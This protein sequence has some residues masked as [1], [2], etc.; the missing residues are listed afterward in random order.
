[1]CLDQWSSTGLGNRNI[2]ATGLSTRRASLRATLVVEET[3]FAA[4]H[5]HLQLMIIHYEEYNTSGLVTFRRPN[6][7]VYKSNELSGKGRSSAS[8]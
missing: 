3:E 8:A 6:D 2:N 7:M 5:A 4:T 1:M